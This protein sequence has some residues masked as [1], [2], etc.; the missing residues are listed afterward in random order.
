MSDIRA[1]Y[2]RA[3]GALAAARYNL[4]VAISTRRSTAP[5]MLRVL[6]Y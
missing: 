6:L 5:T 1:T 3:H 4:E 2:D